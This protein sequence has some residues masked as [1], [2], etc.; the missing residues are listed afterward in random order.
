MVSGFPGVGAQDAS[1]GRTRPGHRGQGERVVFAALLLATVRKSS[2]CAFVPMNTWRGEFE[3]VHLE[4]VVCF[5]LNSEPLRCV[6]ITRRCLTGNSLLT[7]I[8]FGDR[9]QLFKGWLS[10]FRAFQSF[11]SS[12]LSFGHFFAL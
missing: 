2:F 3:Y 4:L 11:P 1:L 12:G 6:G 10:R 5:F 8:V 9:S 7:F